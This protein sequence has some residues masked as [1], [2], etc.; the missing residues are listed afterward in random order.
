MELT[1]VVPCSK[2][3]LLSAL[4]HHAQFA[5]THAMHTY[6]VTQIV[7]AQAGPQCP[8]LVQQSM[9][10]IQFIVQQY[11]LQLENNP[12]SLSEVHSCVQ[13]LVEVYSPL[14]VNTIVL[15]AGVD[16]WLF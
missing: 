9:A 11:S 15:I 7:M 4:I 14:V 8:A 10:H 6:G 1:H 2:Q 16:C 12:Q 3:Q 5:T 13:L